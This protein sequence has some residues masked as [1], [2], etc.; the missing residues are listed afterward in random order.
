MV[1]QVVVIHVASHPVFALPSPPGGKAEAT[2]M[3]LR[4]ASA[5]HFTTPDT[6]SFSSSLVRGQRAVNL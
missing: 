2:K 3:A 4:E 6:Y 5:S 1:M